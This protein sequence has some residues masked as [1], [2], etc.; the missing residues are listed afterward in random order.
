MTVDAM[1]LRRARRAIYGPPI[2][3]LLGVACI[4]IGVLGLATYATSDT[5]TST[6]TLVPPL[7]LDVAS[8]FVLVDANGLLYPGGVADNS[9]AGKPAI[10]RG[11]KIVAAATARTPAGNG[12]WLATSDGRVIGVGVRSLGPQRPLPRGIPAM[13]G[14]AAAQNGGYWLARADGR[15]YAFGAPQYGDLSKKRGVA[16]VGIAAAPDD[17][18]WLATSDGKVTGFATPKRG[19][20]VR[21]RVAP[22]V[23]IAASPGGGYWL[24]SRDGHV[25]AF[26][27]PRRGDAA[28]L[29]LRTHVAAIAASPSGGYWLTTTNGQVYPFGIPKAKGPFSHTGTIVAVVPR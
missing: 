8:S 18:Y 5:T 11:A 16:V 7:T 6:N 24:A 4:A 29:K 27:A 26:D 13:V 19:A 9:S 21:G 1:R 3:G 14:I 25:Y 28:R 23:G 15:V 10:P 22:I 17:G 12:R 2:A 20:A